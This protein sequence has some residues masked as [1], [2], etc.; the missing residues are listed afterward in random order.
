MGVGT[1][2][3][4]GVPRTVFDP[5]V[6][7]VG[8]HTV[9]FSFDAADGVPNGSHP[10]CIQAVSQSVQVNPVP[11]VNPVTS[12]SYCVGQTSPQ[13]NF[14]GTPATGVIYN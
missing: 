14:T 5:A 12:T 3:V 13:I 4:N 6:Q 10:G 2:T 8:T 1:F 7:G 9:T 11:T